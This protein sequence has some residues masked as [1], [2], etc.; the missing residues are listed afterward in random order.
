VDRLLKVFNFSRGVGM[1]GLFHCRWKEQ[2]RDRLAINGRFG[3]PDLPGL[4][5]HADR[6]AVYLHQAKRLFWY[7]ANERGELSLPFLGFEIVRLAPQHDGRP[8][9]LGLLDKL[10]GP[11][12]IL[13][14]RFE[15]GEGSM[16]H[17]RDGGIAGFACPEGPPRRVWV[18]GRE[19]PPSSYSEDS[20]LLRVPCPSGSGEVTIHLQV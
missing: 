13:G 14:T 9:A 11:A 15:H 20:G 19:T 16:C 2:P 10:N 7:A 12:A 3:P 5:D 4:T 8:I 17:L 18:N 1:L 6:F